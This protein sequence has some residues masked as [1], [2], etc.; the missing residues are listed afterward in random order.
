MRQFFTA[1][2][3]LCL[4]LAFSSFGAHAKP[5][6]RAETVV[7][8]SPA[9]G[10]RLNGILRLPVGRGPFPAAVLLPGRGADASARNSA[11][12]QLLSSLADYLV[13]QGGSEGLAAATHPGR[14]LG[15]RHC[16]PVRA[17]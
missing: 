5:F 1:L 4:L 13:S 15:R 14:A 11:D 12:N 10:V 8:T 17:E 3:A 6:D 2:T 7:L 16:G 9:G